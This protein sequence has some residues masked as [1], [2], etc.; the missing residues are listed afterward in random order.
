MHSEKT[1]ALER[2]AKALGADTSKAQYTPDFINSLAEA[3]E[4]GE[5]GGGSGGGSGGG[6][7][8][9]L[10][11]LAGDS[12]YTGAT[13][14]ELEE[15]WESQRPILVK[16]TQYGPNNAE[17]YVTDKNKYYP[18]GET[19]TGFGYMYCVPTMSTMA[20]HYCTLCN[21]GEIYET[22]V[23]ISM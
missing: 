14:A 2:L 13:Y 7:V 4:N 22:V 12:T 11:V 18:A 19:V 21:N 10:V 20:I 15:A 9:P 17:C 3:A 8:E 1:K 16:L 23:T 5:I 6:T